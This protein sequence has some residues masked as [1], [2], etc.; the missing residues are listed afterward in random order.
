VFYAELIY[1]TICYV[2]FID[3]SC[4]LMRFEY[5]ELVGMQNFPHVTRALAAFVARPA[6]QRG[7]EIPQRS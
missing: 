6:V 1:K 2:H 7:L 4:G 3:L 5:S